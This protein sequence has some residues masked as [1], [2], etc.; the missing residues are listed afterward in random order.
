MSIPGVKTIL[1]LKE[2]TKSYDSAGLPT[3]S[4]GSSVQTLSGSFQPLRQ[5]E[6]VD[7]GRV[8]V[9]ANYVF[10][11]HKSQFSSSANEAK[12]VEGNIL[13]SATVE[14][15]IVEINYWNGGNFGIH[16]KV[17]LEVVS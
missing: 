3:L 4:A 7:Y 12:L 8:G 13:S 2:I 5:A 9:T 15:N 1:T 11:F 16:Y 17:V 6:K 10:Y 14:Y